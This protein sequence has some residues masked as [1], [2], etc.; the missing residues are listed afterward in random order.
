MVSL[1]IAVARRRVFYP[2]PILAMPDILMID[3]PEALRDARFP[4]GR[5]RPVLVETPAEQEE[6]EA[7][8]EEERDRV[9]V[10]DPFAA[11]P[12]VLPNP[13]IT[14]AHYGP[15]VEGWPYVILCSW[16]PDLAAAAAAD[17]LRMFIRGAYTIELFVDQEQLEAASDELLALLKRRPG[18]RI[19]I[20]PPDWSADPG[21]R[22]H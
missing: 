1:S 15:P 21:A 20:V 9:F 14:V 12:S 2:R 13:H 10:P 16:P 19:E 22:P 3:L 4:L 7:W 18:T 17:E 5:Y 8:L 6:L 11:R